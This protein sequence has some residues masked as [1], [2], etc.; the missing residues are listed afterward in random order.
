MRLAG[1]DL[2]SQ[3]SESRFA[4]SPDGRKLAM[5]AAADSSRV[6]LW[7]RDLGST[8]LQLL[9]GTENASFPFWSPDSG[10][11]G[12]VAAG[13]L[14]AIRLSD[15][16]V[17]TLS[18]SGFRMAA[19]SRNNLI[20]FTPARASPLHVVPASG[21][22][23]APVTEL[24]QANGDFQHG[25]PAF[26]PDGRHFLYFGIGT[27]AGGPLD[28]RGTYVGSLDRAEP[29]KLLLAGATQARYANGHLLFV[30]RGTL[31]AQAFDVES[32]ELRGAPQP[33]VEDVRL[34]GIGATGAMA[35]FSVSDNG[36]L[37]CQAALR[38]ASR[39]LWFDRAGKQVGVLAGPADYGDLALSHDGAR[40]AVSVTDT[41]QSTGDLWLYDV[42][43]GRG[44][45]LTV[46]A[47][48]E[49]APV[50]SPDGSRLLFSSSSKGLVDLYTKNAGS[51]GDSQMLEVDSQGLG[52]FAADWSRDGR[53]ILYVGGGRA[54]AMSDLWVA[55][56][57]NPRNARA[58]L[59]SPFVETQG[60]FDASRPVVC[61]R[62]E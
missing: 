29:A 47:G 43:S 34:A 13:K 22:T 10:S 11:I 55:P 44:Q 30:Q 46:D 59:E 36:V 54:I 27:R 61:L 51:S 16:T 38:T 60:R 50:W 21:G 25:Y 8:A 35:A 20:L 9:P 58:L 1:S 40:L 5:I 62:V 26:L 15:G 19:W 14:K 39:L 48:D 57:S 37:V 4:V 45:R 23:P 52:R 42:A 53:Y 3:S 12:F 33:L 49:F 56:L 24:D 17:M 7:L 2:A 18:D 32:R 28:P 41:A 31:M 6:Q